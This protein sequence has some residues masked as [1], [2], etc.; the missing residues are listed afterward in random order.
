M[1]PKLWNHGWKPDDGGAG[2]K[3]EQGNGD[4]GL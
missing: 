2:G 3:R 1:L 4:K